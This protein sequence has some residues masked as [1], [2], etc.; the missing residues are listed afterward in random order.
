MQACNAGK[1]RTDVG[2]AQS[3]D[4][5]ECVAGKYQANGG[6]SVCDDCVAGKYGTATN[7]TAENVCEVCCSSFLLTLPVSDRGMDAQ[8]CC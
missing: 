6:K 7:G 3:S 1:Y 8:N 5:L 2:A 4:C